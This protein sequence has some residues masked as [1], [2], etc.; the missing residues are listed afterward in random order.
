MFGQEPRDTAHCAVRPEGSLYYAFK[1]QPSYGSE[2]LMLLV[3]PLKLTDHLR[4]A[5]IC[6][7]GSEPPEWVPLPSP[8]QTLN[9]VSRLHGHVSRHLFEPLFP[10]WPEDEVP[11]GHVTNGV[12]MPSWDSAEADD[13]WTGACGKDRWLGTIEPLERDIRRVPDGNPRDL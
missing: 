12:R 2:D 1:R 11:V 5:G 7:T 10:L 3:L 6:E 4:P 13:L 9:G 8:A